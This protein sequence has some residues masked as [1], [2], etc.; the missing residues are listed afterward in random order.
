M[1]ARGYSMDLYCDNESRCE[2][3]RG[4]QAWRG[5]LSESFVGET[6]AGCARDARARGWS[7][8]RRKGTAYCPLCKGRKRKEEPSE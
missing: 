6:F 3:C 4:D 5:G 8:N 2:Q 1:T 7:V